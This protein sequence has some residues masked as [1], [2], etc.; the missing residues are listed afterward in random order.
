M[1]KIV[2][3]WLMSELTSKAEEYINY[4]IA[5]CKGL[6]S[7]VEKGYAGAKGPFAHQ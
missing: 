6:K 2:K 7:R 1:F 5:R 4:S 3:I